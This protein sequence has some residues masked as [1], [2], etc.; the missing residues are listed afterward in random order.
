MKLAAFDI[1]ISKILPANVTNFKE[2]AP[3]GISCAAAAFSDKPE[4]TFWQGVPKLNRSEAGQLVG[5]LMQFVDEDYTLLTWNGCSFDFFV[6]GQESGLVEECGRLA[7]N[8]ID[9]MLLVAFT[10]GHYLGLDKALAGAG[11]SG[12]LKT[13]T[14]SDGTTI[15][16][17]DGAK[18]PQL[19]AAGEHQ[20]VLEY[21]QGDVSQLIKLADAIKR[22]KAIRWTSN[23]GR[24][25]SV[26]A[27][28]LLPVR[29][30]FNIPEP[31][32]TWMSNPPARAQF[33]DW[34]PGH[35]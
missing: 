34:I 26:P 3:L 19:W 8:H 10:K 35:Q 33:V 28:R 7:L 20:A 1:E 30:C 25:Q 14:L 5:E 9:L 29:E 11:L 18:A 2:H 6:L 32:V 16:D 23:S 13:V 24:P 27:E 12:K 22:H 17:M 15:K 31:D 4:V 21:L